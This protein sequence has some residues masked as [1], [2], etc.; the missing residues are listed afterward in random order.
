ML[1][2][3][4]MTEF[5]HWVNFACLKLK[6]FSFWIISLNIHD[7]RYGLLKSVHQ[8]LIDGVVAFTLLGFK[9]KSLILPFFNLK[10]KS[11]YHT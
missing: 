4:I 3:A 9:V 1:P 2:D 11:V 6:V 7:I 5:S 8:V 10:K